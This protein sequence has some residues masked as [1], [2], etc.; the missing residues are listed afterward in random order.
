MPD[1]AP[2]EYNTQEQ[3]RMTNWERVQAVGIGIVATL[4]VLGTLYVGREFFIPIVLALLLHALL[5]PLVRGLERQRVPT[6]VGATLVGLGLVGVLAGG[7]VVLVRPVQA[8]FG[9]LPA[10]FEAAQRKLAPA[11]QSLEQLS[12][13]TQAG[14]DTK[15]APPAAPASPA[16]PPFVEAIFGT[17][18]ALVAGAIEVLLLLYL[19][20]ASGDLFLRKLVTV[21]P[22][23]Q[24]K[25]TA[26]AVTEEV[27][28][29]VTRYL[30]A[31]LLINIGQGSVV[32]LTLWGLGMPHA[33]L[34]GGLTVLLECIPYLGAIGMMVLLTAA[35]FT[36]FDSIG[37]ILLVP[38]TY[39]L[40]ATLQNNLVSPF[41]Y[42]QRLK[43]NPVAVLVGVLFW[44][45]LW[46]VAGA[47]LAVPILATLKI[48]ADHVERL[49]PLATFLEE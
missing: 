6:A 1:T 23:F 28:Q 8:W 24:D 2:E 35:A 43:L 34:W 39:L 47:F 26:V 12:Q 15:D 9:Q 44:W 25:R 13:A 10:S 14:G 49:T 45:V 5:R 38:G 20:L 21:L 31:T 7:G 16:A 40:I 11:R 19:L 42:G 30:V 29:A 48:L 37:R 22:L 36:Q 41:V 32:G 17:T 4:A 33:W 18:T 3:A 27:Q 46:G